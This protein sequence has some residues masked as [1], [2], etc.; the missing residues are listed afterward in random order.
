M[1]DL[2]FTEWLGILGFGLACLSLLWQGITWFVASR[3]RLK[4]KL[5]RAQR[6]DDHL[7]A[8]CVNASHRRTVQVRKVWLQWGKDRDDGIELGTDLWHPRD[9]RIEPGLI[10]Q[11]KADIYQLRE[12]GMP[13]S[14]LKAQAMVL[15]GARR[16]AYR[17]RHLR[18]AEHHV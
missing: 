18:I 8:E 13:S 6:D 16:R 5:F 12:Q 9:G 7:V 3:V 17:S 14:R 2:T 11:A 15:V 1:A 4:I 10:F